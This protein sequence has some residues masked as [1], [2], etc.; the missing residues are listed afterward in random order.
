MPTPYGSLL[1]TV[2]SV[3]ELTVNHETGP[4]AHTFRHKPSGL[5]FRATTILL[6][7]GDAQCSALMRNDGR[8]R[9]LPKGDVCVSESLRSVFELQDELNPQMDCFVRSDISL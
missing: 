7:L 5:S 6:R 1:F 2:V 9:P 3:N 4:S 8:V